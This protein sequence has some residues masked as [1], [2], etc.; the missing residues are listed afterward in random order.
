[1]KTN[2]AFIPVSAKENQK[3]VLSLTDHVTINHVVKTVQEW[4]DE[5]Y[6]LLEVWK[7]HNFKKLN[8]PAML[9]LIRVRNKALQKSVYKPYNTVELCD[10]LLSCS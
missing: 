4:I 10:V 5:N 2:K 3:N 1:M 7:D 8:T 9:H 6:R